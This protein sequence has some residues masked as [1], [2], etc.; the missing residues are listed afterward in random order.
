MTYRKTI[1]AAIAL[2]AIHTAVAQETK[3]TVTREVTASPELREKAYLYEVTR[4]LYRWYM[5][6]SD[7]MKLVGQESFDFWVR[8]FAPALDEGDRSVFGEI[9]LPALGVSV[10]VKKADYTI[11]ELGVVVKNDTFKIVNVSRLAAVPPSEKY[12]AV[13][14]SYPEMRE[15]LFK[16]RSKIAF[17]EGDLLMR[18]RVAAAAAL[19][20][21]RPEAIEKDVV[22]PQIVHLGGVS[23]VA[24]EVW[25]FWETGR[26]LIRFA[27][28][29][30][31][32]N[33]AVWDNEDLN[34]D[35]YDIDENVVVS[36][37]EVSG[38]NAYMT[39]DQVGRVLFNCVVLGR[40][41]ELIPKQREDAQ[42]EKQ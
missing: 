31:L 1:L 9:V 10:R 42:A 20:K 2:C 6:E 8:D 21:K 38:S 28:D 37:D 18:L 29:I 15:Y 41:E 3:N 39:R 16:T 30:D 27:S 12:V 40:R 19:E 22:G 33:P 35:L 7:A 17:P 32:S 23:P 4:H 24:N 36:L 14:V 26:M 25:L 34:V 11:E 13:P 5:D